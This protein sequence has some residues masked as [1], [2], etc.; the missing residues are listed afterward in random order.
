VNQARW[1]SRRFGLDARSIKT[2]TGAGS[3]NRTWAVEATNGGRYVL[4]VHSNY[5][6]LDAIARRYEAV[7]LLADAGIPVSRPLRAD[8]S[9]YI[10]EWEG[11]AVT[12]C[13]WLAGTTLAETTV[14]TIRRARAARATTALHTRLRACRALPQIHTAWPARLATIRPDHPIRRDVPP[15]EWR[16]L[17]DTIHRDLGLL[18]GAPQTLIHGDLRPAN[19]VVCRDNYSYLDWDLCQQG[20]LVFELAVY[21]L[22]KIAT[23]AISRI[24]ATVLSPLCTNREE[25]DLNLRLVR[26][27]MRVAAARDVAI[28]ASSEHLWGFAERRLARFRAVELR[29]AAA[30][31]SANRPDH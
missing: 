4:K 12:L 31:A 9:A 24:V 22:W 10:L 27:A 23:P 30:D 18:A 7:A 2:L 28:S 16:R 20:P 6:G 25:L 17:I 15:S 3:L 26:P 11:R 13:T 14:R 1:L 19:V 29:T 21:L 5:D 8:T